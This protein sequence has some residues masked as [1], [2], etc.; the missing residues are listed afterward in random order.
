M[1]VGP[2]QYERG[3][4][5]RQD[6]DAATQARI[7]CHP[8]GAWSP[9]LSGRRMNLVHER[10]GSAVSD[11]DIC[12]FGSVETVIV[13]GFQDNDRTIADACRPLAD[14]TCSHLRR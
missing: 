14:C 3:A 2:L 11:R 7:Q 5:G 8:M 9:W 12:I 1:M 6:E 10:A 13:A 4:A